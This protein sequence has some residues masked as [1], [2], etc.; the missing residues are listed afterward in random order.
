M[1]D[2]VETYPVTDLVGYLA[3]RWCLQR[4]IADESGVF[5]GAFTGAASFT[6]ESGSLVYHERGRLEL[7]TYQGDAHRTLHY[8]VTGPGQAE[9]SFDYGDFF[10]EVDLRQ[11]WWRTQHPCRDDLY[12][13]EFR[14]FGPDR[15]QQV[16]VVAGPTK[17]HTLSTSFRR[18]GPG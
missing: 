10:H 13:G 1:S 2:D 15:W 9:V 12:R 6:V 17:N 7:G 3:G 18:S 4:R 8:R 5:L 14:V 11:G 16:W